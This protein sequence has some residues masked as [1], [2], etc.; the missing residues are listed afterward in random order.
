[1]TRHARI[2]ERLRTPQPHHSPTRW[3]ERAGATPKDCPVC[4]GDGL[5][6]GCTECG[7]T[8]T[9]GWTS[10][11]LPEPQPSALDDAR[12]IQ[13]GVLLA[14]ASV[15][16]DRELTPELRGV[17]REGLRIALRNAITYI[18]TWD[19]DNALPEVNF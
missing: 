10:P 18:D 6:D 15:D 11:P 1:M 9:G 4:A 14:F 7:Q 19:E 17:A 16:A 12:A 13:R 3:F 8:P 2:N 5:P